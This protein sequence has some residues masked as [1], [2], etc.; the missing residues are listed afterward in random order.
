VRRLA[1]IFALA[2]VAPFPALADASQQI[3]ARPSLVRFGHTLIVKGSGWPVIEFC[4]R[5][6]RLSLSTSQNAVAIGTVRVKDNGR[7]RF[8]WVPR[9]SKVGAGD[10]LVVARMRCESGKDGS[11][12]YRRA[13][14]LIRIG[15]PL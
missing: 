9:R 5:K 6:V 14:D 1:L 11:I 3:V 12:H 15:V 8:K 13:N 2:A 10:W 4:S 7:F